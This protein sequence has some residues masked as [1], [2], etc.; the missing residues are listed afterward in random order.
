[1]S[2]EKDY[3]VTYLRDG[4]ICGLPWAEY[5]IDCHPGAFGRFSGQWPNGIIESQFGAGVGGLNWLKESAIQKYRNSDC[6]FAVLV[7]VQSRW[8]NSYSTD[9]SGNCICTAYNNVFWYNYYVYIFRCATRQWEDVTSEVL[10]TSRLV[11]PPEG[12]EPPVREGCGE[13]TNGNPPARPATPQK[14]SCPGTFP[15]CPNEFP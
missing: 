15:A 1:M 3:V 6:S 9:E 14:P 4:A 10:H 11:Q 7:G 2:L 8:N 12:F 13:W 5:D